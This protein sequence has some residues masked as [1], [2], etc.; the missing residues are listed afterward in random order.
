MA[1][2]EQTIRGQNKKCQVS[3]TQK[4]F[5]IFYDEVLSDGDRRS[6]FSI[7]ENFRN[8]PDMA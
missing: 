7:L 6:N 4:R 3:K 5:A 8:Y 2:T 1:K